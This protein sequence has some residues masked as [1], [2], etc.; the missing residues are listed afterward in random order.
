[1]GRATNYL[2]VT[3]RLSKINDHD[4]FVIYICV[5]GAASIETGGYS[6]IIKKGETVLLPS[7]IKNY[8][9][10]TN[11]AKLLEIYV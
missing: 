9:I 3:K 11:S 1:M 6:E 7:A 8:S 10:Y 5:D 2:E 4:S